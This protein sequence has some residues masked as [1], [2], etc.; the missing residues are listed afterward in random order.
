[1]NE[2]VFNLAWL[3]KKTK[4]TRTL[5]PKIQYTD[6]NTTLDYASEDLHR[7]SVT[8]DTAHKHFEMQVNTDKTKTYSKPTYSDT[9]K[10]QHKN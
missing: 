9:L 7:L 6:N 5:L 8:Y 2:G 1:M 3:R 10:L 4:N